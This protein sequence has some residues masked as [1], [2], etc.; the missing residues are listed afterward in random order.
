M[1]NLPELPG[2]RVQ[3]TAKHKDRGQ[4]QGSGYG[5]YRVNAEEWGRCEYSPEVIRVVLLTLGFRQNVRPRFAVE[6]PC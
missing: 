2:L 3:E 5:K 4:P 6:R 1:S